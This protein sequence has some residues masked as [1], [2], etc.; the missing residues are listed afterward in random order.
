[1]SACNLDQEPSAQES[2]TYEDLL[3]EIDQLLELAEIDSESE[4]SPYLE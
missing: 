3:H 1:M 4:A 2:Q